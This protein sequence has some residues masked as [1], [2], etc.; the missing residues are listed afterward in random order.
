VLKRLL[1]IFSLHMRR[2]SCLRASGQKSHSTFRS[3]NL[4]FL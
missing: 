2:N 4:D 3:G 1:D